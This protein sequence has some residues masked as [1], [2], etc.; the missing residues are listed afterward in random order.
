ML[1]FVCSRRL[2]P[3]WRCSL[4][5]CCVGLVDQVR[6][7][8]DEAALPSLMESYFRDVLARAMRTSPARIDSRQSL[9]DLGLDSLIAMDVRN[10][11]H[12][13]LSVNVPLSKLMQNESVGA[14]AAYL[15]K[16]LI[17]RGRGERSR[18]A[19]NGPASEAEANSIVGIRHLDDARPA[20][21]RK[22]AGRVNAHREGRLLPRTLRDRLA[23]PRQV[24]HV[25]FTEEQEGQVQVFRLDPF[26]WRSGLS[27]AL[28]E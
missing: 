19:R 25:D 6:L 7:E 23:H 26:D 2:R 24:F 4:L 16:Q 22:A 12:A 5:R 11:L 17:E 15:A 10:R 3:S 21:I 13:E 1:L 8:A 28:L 9:L 18:T 27:E 20:R 14:F